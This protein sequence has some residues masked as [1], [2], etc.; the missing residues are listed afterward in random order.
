MTEELPNEEL[1]AKTLAGIYDVLNDDELT[2]E[3]VLDVLLF[4]L[5]DT[6]AQCTE[7]QRDSEFSSAVAIQ[8]IGAYR[9]HCT[10]NAVPDTVTV[11]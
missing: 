2:L 1:F 10:P 11:Q 5:G 8:L 7:R 9:Y 3:D 4:C 6:M